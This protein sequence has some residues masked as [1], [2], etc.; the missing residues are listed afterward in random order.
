MRIGS[1]CTGYGGLDLAV[2]AVTGGQTIWYAE[3]EKHVSKIMQQHRPDL[4]NYGDLT[5]IEWQNL[6]PVDILTAGY[7]C[8]PFSVAGQRK[9]TDDPR[10]I[11]PHIAR[12]IW[13]LQ[14]KLVVLENVRGH[15]NL[16]FDQVLADLY[17]CGYDARW[18]II[19]ASDI[20]AP[21]QRARLF[22]VAYPKSPRRGT[23]QN[24][25]RTSDSQAGDG[26]GTFDKPNNS[27]TSYAS[28]W[29]SGF[30]QVRNEKKITEFGNHN[31][32]VTDAN[33]DAH[34][35]PRRAD[36]SIRSATSK[37]VNGSDR[38]VNWGRY[39]EAI[40]RWEQL[41]RP[42]PTPVTEDRLEPAFV[43]WMMGLPEGWV[44]NTPLNRN[45]QLKALGNGVV[46]QQAAY[47]L[48]RLLNT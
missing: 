37:V 43:E 22:I 34:Q 42:A 8:Q 20:G 15:L 11:W 9:G 23:Q 10:H 24:R 27:L 36:R 26:L 30:Q 13:L 47:A 38:E 12:A 28:G 39:Q 17:L 4:T 45:Q 32:L 2:E 35:K 7:P 46:P 25:Q 14:P 33:S 21:H 41:T 40:T 3:F 48:K 31:T 44:T 19:R 6:P 1:L 16:G 18:E 5:K 29:G